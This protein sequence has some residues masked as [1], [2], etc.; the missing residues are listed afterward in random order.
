MLA[1]V[2]KPS[3]TVLALKEEGEGMKMATMICKCIRNSVVFSRNGR[4]VDVGEKLEQRKQL[5]VFI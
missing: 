3:R 1:Q 5:L 4:K 2:I